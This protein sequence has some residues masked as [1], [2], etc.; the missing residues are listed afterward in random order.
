MGEVVTTECHQ[1]SQT[2]HTTS[3]VVDQSTRLVTAGVPHPVA[4]THHAVVAAPVAHHGYGKREAEAD[5]DA[6]AAYGH[7]HV[8]AHVPPPLPR[9]AAS[10]L[11]PS[12]GRSPGWSATP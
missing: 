9:P 4:E 3:A 1:T 11:S 6:D 7:G 10:T 8:V 12:P 2:A 5:A